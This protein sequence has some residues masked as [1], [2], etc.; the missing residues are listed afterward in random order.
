MAKVHFRS[1]HRSFRLSNEVIGIIQ[2]YQ[3]DSLNDKLENLVLNTFWQRADLDKEIVLRKQELI[4]LDVK[5]KERQECLCKFD[6]LLVEGER[7]SDQ[8]QQVTA[9]VV[10]YYD[11]LMSL[12][13]EERA[14]KY[15]I[16]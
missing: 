15:V 8:I 4:D 10:A 14:L 16:I 3:G 2:A 7:L 13:D 1:N 11:L 6:R 9:G 5:I 12:T